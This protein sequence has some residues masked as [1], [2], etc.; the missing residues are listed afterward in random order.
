MKPLKLYMDGEKVICAFT[1]HIDVQNGDPEFMRELVI[2]GLHRM[3]GLYETKDGPVELGVEV[4]I[5]DKFSLGAVNVRVEDKTP[6][7]RGRYNPRINISRAY[8]GSGRKG[9]L[10]FSRYVWKKPDVFIN[11]AGRDMENPRS[12]AIICGIVQHEFGHVL[13]FKDKYTYKK[14]NY[15]KSSPAVQDR[16]IMFRIGGGQEF[17]EYHITRLKQC[18]VKGKTPLRKV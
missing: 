3:E 7:I 18:A 11:T 8:F 15:R 17:M 9:L 13:G 10:K 12:R 5:T 1:L 4:N 2:Q 16:D 14:K 6:V